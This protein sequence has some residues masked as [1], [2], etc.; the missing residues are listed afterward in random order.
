MGAANEP[1]GELLLRLGKGDVLDGP[2]LVECRAVEESQG[3]NGAVERTP[4]V[5]SLQ[6]K[7][8]VPCHP[9]LPP[10]H[11]APISV[12]PSRTGGRDPGARSRN[13]RREPL[14]GELWGTGA[15]S[16]PLLALP[17][18]S[19][20]SRGGTGNPRAQTGSATE[21]GESAYA[22]K[23]GRLERWAR[24]DSNLEP[25]DYE[26]PAFGGRTR[27]KWPSA[28]D[29]QGHY[30]MESSIAPP[31]NR[32]ETPPVFR[33]VPR[34]S[35]VP[36]ACGPVQTVGARPSALPRWESDTHGGV[37]HQGCGGPVDRET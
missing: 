11:T 22:G 35:T 10:S 18:P 20:V 16:S 2:I 8:E 28:A 25:R 21:G 29:A 17:R 3:T 6:E 33:T 5:R 19:G 15:T 24:Q 23:F 37:L 36:A 32:T 30:G 9:D 27:M 31:G 12:T 14:W 1:T 4:G 26:S 7:L 34:T 13:R